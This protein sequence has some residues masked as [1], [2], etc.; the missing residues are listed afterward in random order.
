MKEEDKRSLDERLER[1]RQAVYKCTAHTVK[2]LGLGRGL[3]G[4]VP[5]IQVD[6]LSLDPQYPH[7]SE[8]L[9]LPVL[10]TPASMTE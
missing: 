10:R 4:K 2:F 1:Q 5:A 8:V 9:K 7:K 6:D 3:S